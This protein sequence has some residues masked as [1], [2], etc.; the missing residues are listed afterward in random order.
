[1]RQWY[2]NLSELVFVGGSDC[3]MGT[4]TKPTGDEPYFVI[5]S[6]EYADCGRGLNTVFFRGERILAEHMTYA[7]G[8][9]RL[10]GP[11]EGLYCDAEK[12]ALAHLPDILK[13]W[14]KS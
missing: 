1:M 14:K 9:L 4:T 10:S 11:S 12:W 2:I 13:R 7:D 6:D 5:R 3:S 8:S